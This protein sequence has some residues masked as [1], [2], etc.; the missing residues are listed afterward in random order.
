MIHSAISTKSNTDS[1]LRKSMIM[2]PSVEKRGMKIV[3]GYKRDDNGVL[4]T[5][6]MILIM[7][8]PV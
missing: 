8:P 3:P 5:T 6:L 2:M 4:N 7:V 1:A